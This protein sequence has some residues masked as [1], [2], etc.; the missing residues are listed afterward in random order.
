MNAKTGNNI[1]LARASENKDPGMSKTV[2]PKA[3]GMA[4]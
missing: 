4:E 1:R 2:L 3:R